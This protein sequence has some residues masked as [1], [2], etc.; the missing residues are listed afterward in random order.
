MARDI[1][2][3]ILLI[4]LGLIFG[5][6]SPHLA[7]MLNAALSVNWWLLRQELETAW[8]SFVIEAIFI[9]I[10]AVILVRLAKKQTQKDEQSHKEIIDA[11]RKCSVPKRGG[12]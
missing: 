4:I 9:V 3:D 2:R 11:I 8:L 6:A 10:I 5:T 7:T 12:K 1:C